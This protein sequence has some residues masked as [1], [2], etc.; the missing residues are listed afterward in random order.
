MMTGCSSVTND[1]L[2]YKPQVMPIEIARAQTKK[3]SSAILDY[4]GIKSGTITPQDPFT[5]TDARGVARG[6]YMD[7]SWSIYNLSDGALGDGFHRIYKSLPNAG[8]KIVKYGAAND[9]ARTPEIQ[10]EHKD[11]HYTVVIDWLHSSASGKPL[12][13]V[14]LNSPIYVAP[15]GTDM[16]RVN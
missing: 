16:S 2:G 7:H 6:Y 13:M 3:Y 12:L 10:A 11:D 15:E 4:S 8:W 1:N 5:N 14:V 9:K